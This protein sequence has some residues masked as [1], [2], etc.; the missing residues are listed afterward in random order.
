MG[1]VM[2]CPQCGKPSLKAYE[3]YCCAQC[4]AFAIAGI[5]PSISEFRVERNFRKAGTSSKAAA[6][7]AESA[8][9]GNTHRKIWTALRFKPRTPDEIARDTGMVLNTVRARCTDLK[10]T[11][12][13]EDTGER[14]E[15]DAGREAIVWRA[16]SKQAEAA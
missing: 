11:G 8:R 1:G 4:R 16:R 6:A 5:A 12:W 13:I 2:S 7:A 9:L 14:R 10:N 3:P 15:T